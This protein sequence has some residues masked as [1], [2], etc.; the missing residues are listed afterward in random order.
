MEEGALDEGIITQSEALYDHAVTLGQQPTNLRDLLG[1][2]RSLT[3]FIKAE[4]Q[5]EAVPPV[6]VIFEFPD[7][8]GLWPQMTANEKEAV[9]LIT[10]ALLSKYS[11]SSDGN[12]EW[13][14]FL[15]GNGKAPYIDKEH[16]LD[17]GGIDVIAIFRQKGQRILD[18]A[19]A[20]IDDAQEQQSDL[21]RYREADSLATELIDQLQ[22]CYAFTY[23]AANSVERSVN[24]GVLLTYRQIWTPVGYSAGELVRSIPLA[25]NETRKYTK[26]RL[27]KKT[28][29]EKELEENVRITKD[30]TSD[31]ARSET[32][33]V[34]K[35]MNKTTFALNTTSTFDIPLSDNIKIGNTITSNTTK[36]AQQDSAETKKE[37]RELVV[38]ASQE[39][40]ATRRT[41]VSVDTVSEEE[42]AESGEIRNTSAE[43]TVTYLIYEL[44]RQYRVNERLHRMRPVVLVAQEMPAPHEID[45]AWIVRHDWI[46]KRALMDDSLLAA[47]DAINTIRGDQLMLADLERVVTDQRNIVRDL[48]QKRPLL[49]RRDRAH[50]PPPAGGGEQGSRC[51]R[52]PRHLGRD[53]APRLAA[54][55]GGKRGEGG[56]KPH[57]LRSGGRPEGGGAHPARGDQGRVRARGPGAPRADGAARTRDRRHERADEGSRRETQGDQRAGGRDHASQEPPDGPHP[58]LHAGD[59]EL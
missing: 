8:V 42:S 35:A 54:R 33:I 11:D 41:E 59:L 3:R 6:E 44:Q 17:R 36:D 40:R 56:G 45:D 10:A 43:I 14:D 49:H 39:Y 53:P 2:I 37:F 52:G 20:R 9:K 27:V 23:F 48:R 32:E 29:S 13:L 46:I 5:Q 18:S 4:P 21:D 15:R 22:G 26:R 34:S 57:R 58:A 1:N 47:F 38:K 28:R 24:F 50:E 31:T 12:T 16:L 25:P 7:A 30:D 51:R 55:H 19:Q